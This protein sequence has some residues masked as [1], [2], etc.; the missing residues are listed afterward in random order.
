MAL[1]ERLDP[2]YL[3]ILKYGLLRARD[4][5]YE[6]TIDRV[7]V[8]TEHLHE[9]PTLIGDANLYRHYDYLVRMRVQYLD[10]YRAHRPEMLEEVQHRF[11]AVW[12]RMADELVK[13]KREADGP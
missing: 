10:W 11:G 5:A 7:R 12:Q 3:Y 13:A 6:A 8:E 2:D 1:M 4:A 9:I